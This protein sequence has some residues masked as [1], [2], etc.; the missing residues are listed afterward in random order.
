MNRSFEP[1][2]T[3]RV[4]AS[5]TP[6]GNFF[7]RTL[8]T[9]AQ[10][11]GWTAVGT[12]VGIAGVVLAVVQFAAPSQGGGPDLE[13]AALAVGTPDQIDGTKY[14]SSGGNP[15]IPAT[16]DVS[17][18]DIT[19][20]NSGGEPSVITR[21]TAE[22]VS[23]A[24]LK[25]C[26]NS[27]AG[28]AA[29]TANY[30]IRF[31]LEGKGQYGDLNPEPQSTASQFTVK[32]GSV[33]RM[34]VTVGPEDQG[35]NPGPTV[36]A[37]KVSLVHDGTQ[38]LDVGTVALAALEEKI[39]QQIDGVLVSGGHR[40]KSNDPVCAA[41]NLTT[42]DELYAAAAVRSPSLDRLRQTYEELAAR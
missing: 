4:A 25:D 2:P 33:D 8:A 41:E 12:V 16:F 35:G 1:S 27:G 10:H 13:V 28:P 19:L 21:V 18:I 14:D 22:V 5:V 40:K 23:S 38:I 15:D 29:I 17:P 24:I 36:L 30:A 6:P 42:L 7:T 32:P 37:V 20:K 9:L 26:T 3:E 31:P 11:P 39:D 34:Q